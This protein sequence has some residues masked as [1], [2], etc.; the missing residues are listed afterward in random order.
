MK[1]VFILCF[2]F[3]ITAL[4][5]TGVK[6]EE[7]TT[8]QEVVFKNDGAK[9]LEDFT[10]SDYTR[11]YKKLGKKRFWGWRTYTYMDD[12]DC[13]FIQETLYVITNEGDTAIDEN[14]R[15]SREGSLKKFFSASGSLELSGKGDVKGFK[16]GLEEK[17]GTKQTL[18]VSQAF[19]EVYT[20]KISVDPQ[21]KL[22]I[23]IAGEGKVTNGVGRYYR[24]FK[25][26]KKGGWEIF[27]VTTE[28]YSIYK[29]KL[30]TY[31]VEVE[32][33]EDDVNED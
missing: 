2:M 29:Q 32:V 30:D 17:V 10:N 16:L 14:I 4:V 25:N 23:S 31:V 8:F 21:T 20:L 24:F 28:Y 18:T 13:T 19:E 1:K 9:L 11:A 12:E 7:Y 6:A 5:T 26:A 3:M 33:E 15:L 27:V 22:T